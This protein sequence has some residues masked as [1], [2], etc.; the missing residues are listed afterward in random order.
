MIND[1]AS[2]LDQAMQAPLIAVLADDVSEI[3]CVAR[4]SPSLLQDV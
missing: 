3:G 1:I 2:F 4:R